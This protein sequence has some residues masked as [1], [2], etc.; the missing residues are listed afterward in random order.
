MGGLVK[1]ERPDDWRR[2]APW[3]RAAAMLND[4]DVTLAALGLHYLWKNRSRVASLSPTAVAS[5]S[6]A[7]FDAR[8]PVAPRLHF[9]AVLT[10]VLGADSSKWPQ[11]E[12]SVVDSLVLDSSIEDALR[13]CRGE[14]DWEELTGL[15]FDELVR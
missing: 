12:R 14:P 10:D 9:A 1:D 4:H 2:L 15:P 13:A 8:G 6:S 7:Q 5:E 11:F 3:W